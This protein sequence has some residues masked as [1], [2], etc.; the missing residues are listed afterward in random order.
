AEAASTADDRVVGEGGGTQGDHGE[1]SEHSTTLGR[2]PD[3]AGATRA[4]TTYPGVA[5]AA[6]APDA[7]ADLVV[8]ECAVGHGERAPGLPQTATL[9]QAAGAAGDAE[10]SSTTNAARATVAAG[11]LIRLHVRVADTGTAAGDEQAA[12]LGCAAG[13]AHLTVASRT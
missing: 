3:A 13:A 11:K 4:A 1:G 2:A 12:A 7:A 8:G 10:G 6:R 5:E 9:R